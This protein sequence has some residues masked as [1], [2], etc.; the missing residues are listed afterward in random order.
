MLGAA[1]PVESLAGVPG[2]PGAQHAAGS[3]RPR[4]LAQRFLA[5]S[6]SDGPHLR[7]H[8]FREQGHAL[9]ARGDW[10]A[11]QELAAETEQLVAAN[12]DTAFCYAVTTARAFGVVA[13][14][15]AGRPAEARE[16]LSRAELPLQAEPL[17]RESV[18]LLA[19][20]AWR[21]R[22]RGAA[23]PP[24]PRAGATQFWFFHRMEA[25]VLTMLER[26]PELADVCRASSA[27]P[28][29]QPVPRGPAGSHPRGDE[30]G[31]RWPRP[32]A[33][34]LRSSGMPDGASCWLPARGVVTAS[35]RE[36]PG[37]A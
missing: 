12:P 25:V 16:L 23:P 11:L 29:R 9:L 6:A 33:W 27:S 34:Q 30:R 1:A 37:A 31:A 15:L 22:R 8:S 10:R 24:G 28:P 14:A 21:A 35:R 7:T 13:H 4:R 17:E 2:H 5:A 18:L 3:T 32:D 19:Y 26:W 36:R 20:G